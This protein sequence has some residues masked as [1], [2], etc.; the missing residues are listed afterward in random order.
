MAPLFCFWGPTAAAVAAV[1]LFGEVFAS[2][3]SLNAYECT[4]NGVTTF[5][6]Q[7]C[8]DDAQTVEIEYTNPDAASREAARERVETATESTD[9]F[10]DKFQL[11]R[12]IAGV[13]GRI[14]DLQKQRD[15]ELRILRASAAGVEAPTSGGN[16]DPST[17]AVIET[18]SAEGSAAQMKAVNDRYAADIAVEQQRLQLLLDRQAALNPRAMEIDALERR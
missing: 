5:S 15:A 9:Q 17:A 12:A 11:E 3:N 18:L 10:L 1:A 8:S 6:D 7:P 2:E 13:E 16:L 4:R 14:S